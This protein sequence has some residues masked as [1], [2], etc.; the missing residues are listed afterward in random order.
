[1]AASTNGI[2]LV[3]YDG[4]SWVTGTELPGAPAIS[5]VAFG[6]G[7]F[8]AVGAK[9]KVFSSPDGFE[10]IEHS[11]GST[12]SNLYDVAYGG[13]IYVAG[14]VTPYEAIFYRSTNGITWTSHRLD[15]GFLPVSGIAYGNGRFVAAR[16]FDAPILTSEDG[17]AWV[18]EPANTPYWLEDVKYLNGTFVA[19]GRQGLIVTSPDGLT[20]T[21]GGFGT[22]DLNAVRFGQGQYI[23]V[24]EFGTVLTSSNAMNWVPRSLG[25]IGE[26]TGVVYGNGRYVTFA[27][28]GYTAVSSNAVDWAQNRLDGGWN[29]V[30]CI[31]TNGLF[32]LVGGGIWISTDGLVWT[33]VTCKGGI[34]RII[35]ANSRFLT[36][37]SG[38]LQS[39]PWP[40][41]SL[42][43]AKDDSAVTI[44]V[45]GP[46][47]F[48]H[49]LEYSLDFSQWM[50]V[51]T[52]TNAAGSVTF[53]DTN[54]TN[55][56]KFYRAVAR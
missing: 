20:W 11:A 55:R 30:D 48:V 23:A 50:Q 19:V 45:N 49:D 8:V 34:Y 39:G 26:L 27:S 41:F 15:D 3:S 2:V 22:R 6:N 5:S 56:T 38:I 14:G 24:G 51:D 53:R 54:P 16:W 25:Y 21:R 12:A 32:V 28:S 29:F 46:T 4:S 10:W 13:G 37:G 17:I 52:V 44:T 1:V 42:A 18:P 9:G 35:Y 31:Y 36:V 43:A 33:P 47:G 40:Q 7:R